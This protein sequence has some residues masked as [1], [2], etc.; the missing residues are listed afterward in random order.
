MNTKTGS[1]PQRSGGLIGGRK[2][3]AWPERTS[4]RTWMWIAAALVLTQALGLHALGRLAICRCG[5]VKLWHGAVFSSENS[6]HVTDWFSFAHVV[7]GMVFYWIVTRATRR[8]PVGLRFVL[9]VLIEVTWELAENT[10]FV[11]DRYRTYTRSLDY[12]GDTIVNSVAD[13]A[14]CMIGF[15]LAYRLP[16]K[17]TVA[18]A[19]A[20]ELFVGAA[21]RDNATLDTIMLI[22]PIQAIR[23]WQAGTGR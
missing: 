12:Y 23:T 13:T 7:A 5:Y 6:Q 22:Y 14:F 17:A 15:A 19:L 8:G 18:L 1:K 21:I 9:V 2:T 3:M 10:P 16:A 20:M 11:M 4:W